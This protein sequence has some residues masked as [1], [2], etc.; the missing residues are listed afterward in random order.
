MKTTN[1]TYWVLTGLFAFIMFGSAIPDFLVM[2]MAV[3]GFQDMGYPAY[4]VPF[5][6]WAKALGVIAILVPGFPRLKEWAYAG[7]CF[8][9][10]GA[11]YSLISIGKPF[12]EWWPM[13][14]FVA[15][16]ISSYLY[17]HKRMVQASSAHSDQH[18]TK[19][20]ASGS[21]LPA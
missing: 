15:L 14:I 13:L 8:D 12:G 18:P 11:T 7:L 16:G 21:V 20:T 19:P 5:L 10:L 3:K 9:L 6:G 17:Y 4:L 2:P 1:I